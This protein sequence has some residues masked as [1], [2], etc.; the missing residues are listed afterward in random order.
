MCSNHSQN[1]KYMNHNHDNLE[2]EVYTCPM[3]SEVQQNKPGSCPKCGMKLVETEA[4][5]EPN[6]HS[7]HGCCH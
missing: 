7:S 3:H 4:K 1:N 5:A 2:S 6:T